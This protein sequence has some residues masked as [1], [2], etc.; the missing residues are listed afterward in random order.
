MFSLHPG[1]TPILAVAEVVGHLGFQR[2]L[3][4]Q[5]GELLEQAVL[6]N[7]V[8]RFPIFSQQAVQQLVGYCLLCYGHHRSLG[9][10][11]FLPNDRLHKNSFTPAVA[12]ERRRSI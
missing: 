12:L 2:L 11:S 9:R 4:Q 5:L 10:G 7:Q 8:F 3:D 1:H 6:A